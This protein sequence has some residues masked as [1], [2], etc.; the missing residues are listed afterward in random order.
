MNKSKNVPTKIS[1]YIT[2]NYDEISSKLEKSTYV[3]VDEKHHFEKKIRDIIPCKDCL[4]RATCDGGKRCDILDHY[5][6]MKSV[7]KCEL[8]GWQI[9]FSKNKIKLLESHPGLIKN[10][11]FQK[12]DKH[13]DK[14]DV[15]Y[16][17]QY[18]S[19]I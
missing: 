6:N 14:I 4:V 18:I 9:Y 15:D 5:K 16:T 19:E 12:T 2:E 10:E 11:D 7:S 17:K 8:M 3:K 1:R 13:G